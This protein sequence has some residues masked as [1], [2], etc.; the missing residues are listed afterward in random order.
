MLNEKKLECQMED[1]EEMIALLK[2]I[3]KDDRKIVKGMV[4]GMK[5]KNEME[6]SATR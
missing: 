1:I 3:T 5:M 6:A 4:L 2:D